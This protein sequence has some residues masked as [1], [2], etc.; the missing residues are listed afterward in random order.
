MSTYI[1]P[2]RKF[3]KVKERVILN[4]R[5]FREFLEQAGCLR[6]CTIQNIDFRNEDIDW[7]KVEMENTTFLGCWFNEGEISV[8]SSMGAFVYPRHPELPYNPYRSELYTWQ[9]LLEGFDPKKDNSLD[10]GIYESFSK[11]R[12]NPDINAA[13]N[14]RVH[15]HSIDHAL[16]RLIGYSTNG[17]TKKKSVGIMGGHGTLRTDPFYK[18][19]V[20][21]A[22]L[23]T[24]S[25]FY[26]ASGGGPGIMEAANLGAWMSGRSA[27]E[28]ETAL[29]LLG[30]SPH[31]SDNGYFEA[32]HA[33]LRKF[34]DGA[35]SLAIPTWFYGHEPSNLFATHIAKYFSNSIREDTLL[36]VSL[37]GVVF[38]P[39]SAGTSQEIFMEATQNHYG[40]FNY[41]S[42][43]VFLGRQ[44]YEIDTMI[45]PLVRQLSHGQEYHDLLCLTDEPQEVVDFLA[46]H[47]PVLVS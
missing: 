43:M 22:K 32:A 37:H 10:L 26:V 21:T 8:L 1:R 6:D 18:R 7:L 15:D 38:A 41:Y 12:F 17:M 24:E 23:L 4:I 13:L 34:P 45:Y 20:Y 40:T 35:E 29:D 42:P 28:V 25:G 47:P 16:R 36:A 11:N 5:S 39:G 31:Y 33:L 30:K 14:Q 46:G 44:R 27:D 2:N 3:S 19:V 9:E